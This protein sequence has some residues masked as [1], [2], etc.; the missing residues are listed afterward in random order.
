M[1]CVRTGPS[2][3]RRSSTEVSG[4]AKG[5]SEWVDVPSGPPRWV[6]TSRGTTEV[7]GRAKWVGVPGG[8]GGTGGVAT[9]QSRPGSTLESG[10]SD[11]HGTYVKESGGARKENYRFYGNFREF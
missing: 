9:R 1:S 4:R 3:P 2:V 7:G 8:T 10:V 11:T 6:D 5:P